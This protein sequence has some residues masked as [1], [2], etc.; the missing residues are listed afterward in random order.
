MAGGG[1]SKKKKKGNGNGNSGTTTN[2]KETSKERRT[3][4]RLSKVK[5]GPSTPK[6]NS[7][8]SQSKKRNPES[9]EPPCLTPTR[10]QPKSI[11]KTSK[12][13][14]RGSRVNNF[15]PIANITTNALKSTIKDIKVE[16]VTLE[17]KRAFYTVYLHNC[18][19]ANGKVKVCTFKVGTVKHVWD[20]KERGE[21]PYFCMMQKTREAI[22]NA[23][24]K[25]NLDLQSEKA[26]EYLHSEWPWK[27]LWATVEKELYCLEKAALEKK[28]SVLKGFET[29][30]EQQQS[31]V[32]VRGVPYGTTDR[33]FKAKQRAKSAV[34]LQIEKRCDKETAKAEVVLSDIVTDLSSKHGLDET[35]VKSENEAMRIAIIDSASNALKGLTKS[36]AISSLRLVTGVIAVLLP[37]SQVFSLQKFCDILG[38]NRLSKYVKAV[39]ENRQ[40]YN[41]YLDKT[42]PILVGEKGC[43]LMVSS[44]PCLMIRVNLCKILNCTVKNGL[45]LLLTGGTTHIPSRHLWL[46]TLRMLPGRLPVPGPTQVKLSRLMMKTMSPLKAMHLPVT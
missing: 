25:Y 30:E 6:R 32:W 45:P 40:A 24:H 14:S 11:Q 29:R 27:Y 28:N 3:S 7:K 12:Q 44:K 33:D 18:K 38:I 36:F 9:N 13:S 39:V 17:N 31:K 4:R 8:K 21:E 23:Q 41:Q 5:N 43:G 2:K 42:G 34:L 1:Q 10:I 22:N 26:K 15:N 46:H 19:D 16:G 20:A 37:L 35:A